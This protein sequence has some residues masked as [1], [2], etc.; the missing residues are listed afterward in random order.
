[1]KYI[2]LKIANVTIVK[3]IPLNIANFLIL[4]NLQLKTKQ[5]SSFVSFVMNCVTYSTISHI[6]Q[7]RRILVVMTIYSTPYQGRHRWQGSWVIL[8]YKMT[9]V[10]PSDDL[11]V[12]TFWLF[13]N[14]NDCTK[15]FLRH[16]KQDSLIFLGPFL[17]IGF[18]SLQYEFL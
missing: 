5:M 7:K 12:S 17:P 4:Y 1:M 16:L 6:L 14:Y 10:F 18:V 13:H 11:L 8:L 9:N 2:H 15:Y 3:Y